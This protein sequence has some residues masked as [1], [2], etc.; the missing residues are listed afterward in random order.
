MDGL[1][2]VMHR[3]LDFRFLHGIHALETHLRLEERASGTASK[4]G[5]D[6]PCSSFGRIGRTMIGTSPSALLTAV[7]HLRY[8]SR[9]DRAYDAS[10]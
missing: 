4:S 5:G 3:T 7:D 1:E 8:C 6:S 10:L 9:L 2:D